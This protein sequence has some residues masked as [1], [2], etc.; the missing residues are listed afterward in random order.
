M[1]HTLLG[2]GMRIVLGLALLAMGAGRLAA[3]GDGAPAPE[4]FD[5]ADRPAVHQEMAGAYAFQIQ[6]PWNYPKP[7]NAERLYPLVIYLHGGGATAPVKSLPC[8]GFGNNDPAAVAMQKRYPCFVCAPWTPRTWAD[9]ETMK[10][11]S[12]AIEHLKKTYRIDPKRVYLIG[13]S[14]GGSGTYSIADYYVRNDHQP[15]AGV[16]RLAGQSRYPDSVHESLSHSSVW[17]HIGLDDAPERVDRA[18]EAYAK[19]K[20]L[21][22]G[23][24]ESKTPVAIRVGEKVF[25]GETL[26]LTQ[27]GREIAKKT[28]YAGMDHGGVS[29]HPFRDDALLAWLFSQRLP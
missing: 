15:F 5:D 23:A 21:H 28:E 20:A 2:S 22:A 17:L 24:V 18:R 1:R 10:D 16:V 3:G 11:V 13:F 6:H 4:T 29:S 7:W 12:D 19:L 26:T 14:M 9:P 8:L 25:Q 27:D